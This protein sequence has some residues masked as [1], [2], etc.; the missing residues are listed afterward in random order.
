LRQE[1]DDGDAR[2]TTDNSDLDILGVR[3]LDLRDET[4]G[5]DDIKGGDT[6]ETL[7]VEDTSL[8]Q[9][10]GKDGDSGVDRVGDDEEVSVGAVPKVRKQV[11]IFMY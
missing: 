4:R 7:G 3:A 10:L 8:L 5:T 2:V 1:R 6:I 11:N 9:G